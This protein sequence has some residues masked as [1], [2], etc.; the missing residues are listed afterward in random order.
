MSSNDVYETK[1]R[2][3]ID[4]AEDNK[5]L[6]PLTKVLTFSCQQVKTKWCRQLL[7]KLHIIHDV[8]E[9]AQCNI[10]LDN[11]K[12][13]INN[14]LVLINVSESCNTKLLVDTKFKAPELINCDKRSKAGDVWAS[15]ICI[16]YIINLSFPWKIAAKKDDNF[17]LWQNKGIFSS[18]SEGLYSQVLIQMLCVDPNMR[19][20][21]K[22]VIKS[23]CD[24][25]T[26]T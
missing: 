16:Y 1:R 20:S 19:V 22:E 2:F 10:C 12:V 4:A 9:N 7:Y 26:V 18:T 23:T 11:L 17:C 24:N 15:L 6:V 13:D 14:D 21:I 8:F 3:S 5:N 25:K